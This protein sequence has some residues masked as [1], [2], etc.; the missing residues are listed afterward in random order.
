MGV[1]VVGIEVKDLLSIHDLSA[2]EIN[3]IMNLAKTLKTQLKTVSSI[4]C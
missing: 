4:I 3:D 2:K 1:I